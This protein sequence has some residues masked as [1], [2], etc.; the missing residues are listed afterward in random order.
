MLEGGKLVGYRR[1]DA[2][3]VL[4]ALHAAHELV[5]IPRCYMHR[6]HNGIAAVR[7]QFGRHPGRGLDLGNRVADDRDDAG[8]AAE[9][10]RHA[11]LGN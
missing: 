3:N 10:G 11:V 1:D 5:K 2:V 4:C 9:G 8:G 7:Q 6:H